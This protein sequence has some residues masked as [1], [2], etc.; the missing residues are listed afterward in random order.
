MNVSYVTLAPGGIPAGGVASTVEVTDGI[1]VDVD[2]D[3]TVLG[4]EVIGGGNWVDG[5]VALAMQGRLQV[6]PASR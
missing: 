4:I 2:K 5:L 3:R 6:A 1:L